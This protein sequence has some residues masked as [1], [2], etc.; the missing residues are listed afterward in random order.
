MA[1]PAVLTRSTVRGLVAA[2][3]VIALVA[4]LAGGL[5]VHLGSVS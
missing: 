2:A 5:I 1:T 4:G 3:S